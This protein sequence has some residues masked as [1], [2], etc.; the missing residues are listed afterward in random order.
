M[1]RRDET[2][3][4]NFNI[5][6][7]QKAVFKSEKLFQIIEIPE[8]KHLIFVATYSRNSKIVYIFDQNKKFIKS[9]IFEIDRDFEFLVQNTWS[10]IKSLDQFYVNPNDFF[11]SISRDYIKRILIK[12]FDKLSICFDFS[13]ISSTN[14][15]LFNSVN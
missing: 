8:N 6:C 1:L 13:L 7:I 2:P 10:Y 12:K 9:V 15:L 4:L 14:Y 3:T 11:Y 5:D